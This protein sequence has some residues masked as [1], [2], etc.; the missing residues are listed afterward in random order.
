MRTFRLII[1]V[2][3]FPACLQAQ[4]KIELTNSLP[5]PRHEEVIEIPWADVLQAWPRIDTAAFV[6]TETGTG[7]QVPLQLL[8]GN[9]GQVQALL[10][11]VSVPASAT[12]SLLLAPG[13]R[14][15]VTPKTYCRYVPERKDDFAWEND[16]IA[17]RAYGTALE[18]SPAENAYGLDVWVKRTPKLVID[19]RYKLGDYHKDHGDGVDYY[20][21]GYTLGAGQLM[22]FVND[23]I[24]YSANYRRWKILANGPLRSVFQLEY[25]PWTVDGKSVSAVRTVT[26]DAGAQMHRVDVQFSAASVSSLPVV[27]G[28][29]KR[30]EPGVVLFD[31]QQQIMAYWDPADPAFGVTGVAVYLPSG[32]KKMMTRGQQLL[33]LAEAP[34]AQP[35]TYYRGAAWNKAGEIV[36]AAQWFQ[37]LHAYREKTEHPMRIKL[38]RTK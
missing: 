23:S 15:P 21:V 7:R 30:D 20:H 37:Y 8:Q 19:Q 25:D 32:T 28:I 26:I 9:N 17:F 38:T 36:S 27:A 13:K 2:I 3:L 4:V 35:F 14:T 12:K 24:W 16:K 33:A 31:E 6:V 11:Q 22:P 29:I 10:L 18:A 34:V 1:T 5:V